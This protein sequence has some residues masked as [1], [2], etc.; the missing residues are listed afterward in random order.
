MDFSGQTNGLII[1]AS[2]SLAITQYFHNHLA[3]RFVDAQQ[4]LKVAF[5][6]KP[7]L[8]TESMRQKYDSLRAKKIKTA[9]PQVCFLFGILFLLGCIKFFELF[10]ALNH[11]L[12]N[13]WQFANIVALAIA[14][15]IYTAV[16]G[17][18]DKIIDA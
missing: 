7:H 2:A 17:G 5:E 10:D 3:N 4:K 18:V 6:E 1:L 16:L 9:S 14:T 13:E 8:I 12:K 11:G 15:F